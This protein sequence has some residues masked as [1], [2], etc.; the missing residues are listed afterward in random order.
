[1]ASISTAALSARKKYGESEKDCKTPLT[2]KW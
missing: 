1:M 2:A